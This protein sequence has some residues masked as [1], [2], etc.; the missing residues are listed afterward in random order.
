MAPEQRADYA[1]TLRSLDGD[2]GEPWTWST[3][4]EFY[5]W[6][7][8]RSV[9][10]LGLYLGHSAVRRRVM[11]NEP[12]AATDSELRAMADV[13]RQEAPATLGLSTG[14]IYS[15]AVFSDQRELTEL[16]RAFNTV[17]PGAL[18]PHIRSE[19]DNILTAMKEV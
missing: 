7:R 10:D 19:S 18:F 1:E 16:L 15:P 13:V 4:E 6:H 9:T 2:I 5:A 3:V 11:G 14:L 17:K 8:G 12:R